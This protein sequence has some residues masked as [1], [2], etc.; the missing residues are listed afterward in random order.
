MNNEKKPQLRSNLISLALVIFE[1][2]LI[3]QREE[4]TTHYACLYHMVLTKV[5]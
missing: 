4:P 3:M 2:C 1:M 5:D